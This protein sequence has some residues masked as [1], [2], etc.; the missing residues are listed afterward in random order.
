MKDIKR[1]FL[2]LRKADDDLQEANILLEAGRPDGTS[3]RAYYSMYHS[4]VALLHTTDSVLT[5]THTGA[6]T[7]F[8]RQFV[9]TTIFPAA[10]SGLI[11]KLFNMRQGGDYEPEFDISIEDAE[12]AV[13]QA[14]DFYGRVRDYL[15]T[16]F[17]DEQP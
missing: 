12:D 16:N 17:P 2:F 5:K 6:H 9:L 14:T 7:E 11:T 13:V 10:D 4:I 3:N 8:R 15:L 1:A